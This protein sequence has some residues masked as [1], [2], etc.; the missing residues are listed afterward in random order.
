[1]IRQRTYSGEGDQREMIRLVAFCIGWLSTGD[2]D[3]IRGQIEPLG[4]H[5]DFSRYALGRLALRETL[6]RLQLQGAKRIFVET[7][8]YRNTA[9]RLYESVGFQVIR[10]IL[11]Y[12][13]S[14]NEARS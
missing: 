2:G 10:E 6:R 5:A 14:Y 1:M 3:E 8:S 13:K 4:C 7:D 11:V 12:G 9:F